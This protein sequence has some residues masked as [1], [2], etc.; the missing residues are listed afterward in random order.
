MD[1]IDV[2]NI[3]AMEIMHECVNKFPVPVAL[4]GKDISNVVE[5]FFSTP[6]STEEIFEHLVKIE[7]ICRYTIVWLTQ[8]D[9]LIEHSSNMSSYSVTLSQKGLNTLNTAPS[10]I[11]EKGTFRALI[12]KGLSAFSTSAASGLMVEFFK[13]GY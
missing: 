3:A 2:F 5:G 12:S 1:S 6:E 10:S 13:N 4:S 8:E 7:E 9:F 11:E